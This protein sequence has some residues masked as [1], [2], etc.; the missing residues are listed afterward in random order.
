MA[1][2]GITLNAIEVFTSVRNR[3]INCIYKFWNDGHS[4]SIVEWFS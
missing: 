2:D 1:E 3:Q 4:W